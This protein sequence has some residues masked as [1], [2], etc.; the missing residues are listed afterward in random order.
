MWLQVDFAAL[1]AEVDTAC[2]TWKKP[3]L[4]L[5]G[6]NDPFINPKSTFDF[7]DD[8]RTNFELAT[9]AT[10]VA[11]MPYVLLFLLPSCCRNGTDQICCMS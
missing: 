3:T 5:F 4:L 1:L 2:R 10:R 8:K 7:L 6:Q 9:L 11:P